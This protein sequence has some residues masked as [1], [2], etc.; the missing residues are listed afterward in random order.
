VEYYSNNKYQ[1]FLIYVSTTNICCADVYYWFYYIL[2]Y[3]T[4]WCPL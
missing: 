2:H 3:S 4:S 1:L